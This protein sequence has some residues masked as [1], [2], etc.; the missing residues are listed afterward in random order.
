GPVSPGSPLWTYPHTCWQTKYGGASGAGVTGVGMGNSHGPR[1][2]HR[3]AIDRSQGNGSVVDDSVDHHLG[4]VV[5]YRHWVRSHGGNFPR[6]LIFPWQICFRGVNP[7][8]MVLH[9]SSLL[10]AREYCK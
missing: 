8:V 1:I 7:E 3:A 6:K 5:V 10:Q 4:D 9:C 2:G